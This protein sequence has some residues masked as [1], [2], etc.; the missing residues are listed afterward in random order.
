MLKLVP[1]SARSITKIKTS[2]STRHFTLGCNSFLGYAPVAFQHHVECLRRNK[3]VCQ[4]L[5]GASSHDADISSSLQGLE[6]VTGMPADTIK[7]LLQLQLTNHTEDTTSW[8]ELLTTYKDVTRGKDVFIPGLGNFNIPEVYEDMVN[9]RRQ[10]YASHLLHAIKSPYI[11]K[12]YK[13]ILKDAD[14]R[15]PPLPESNTAEDIRLWLAKY[16]SS[17]LIKILASND[18]GSILKERGFSL[19]NEPPFA[20]FISSSMSEWRNHISWQKSLC[21]H[22]FLLSAYSGSVLRGT[23]DRNGAPFW[24]VSVP[25]LQAAGHF[26]KAL[27]GNNEDEQN[28]LFYHLVEVLSKPNDYPG[29]Q[30]LLTWYDFWNDPD[31]IGSIDEICNCTQWPEGWESMGPRQLLRRLREIARITSFGPMV[32]YDYLDALPDKGLIR[33]LR[34]NHEIGEAADKLG[35]CA[36]SYIHR[37]AQESLILVVLTNSKGKAIA[38]G[39]HPLRG[40]WNERGWQEIRESHNMRASEP[41]LDSFHRYSKTFRY[42]HRN[43]YVPSRRR[44]YDDKNRDRIAMRYQHQR[45]LVSILRLEEAGENDNQSTDIIEDG[46]DNQTNV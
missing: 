34:S 14:D 20:P 1:I 19:N 29:K 35:N 31:N 37:V 42:W 16:H 2:Q 26:S 38:M 8:R 46:N 43:V 44:K 18:L 4:N 3:L 9:K 5:K 40:T 6:K 27:G 39:S 10:M 41:T 21:Q 7:P 45:R 11:R 15:L 32:K 30:H 24:L 23:W 33:V 25:E 13:E 17:D 12:A 22:R 36:H 28:N